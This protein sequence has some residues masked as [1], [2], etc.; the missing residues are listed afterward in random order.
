MIILIKPVAILSKKAQ[1]YSRI[2]LEHSFVT[3]CFFVKTKMTPP[4]W[5]GNILGVFKVFLTA[6][7]ELTKITKSARNKKKNYCISNLFLIVFWIESKEKVIITKKLQ[8]ISTQK[9]SNYQ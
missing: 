9:L 5:S 7:M 2:K 4:L 6:S 1:R 8:L 3:Q